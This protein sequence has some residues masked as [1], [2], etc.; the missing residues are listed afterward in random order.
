MATTTCSNC[1][2]PAKANPCEDCV[3]DSKEMMDE[4]TLQKALMATLSEAPDDYKS[5]E[6]LDIEQVRSVR[7]FQDVGM[8]TTD[9]GLL[10]TMKDGSEFQITIVQSRNARG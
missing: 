4:K 9:A 8:L 6:A 10:I 2:N 3:E 1:G 7:T 5:G